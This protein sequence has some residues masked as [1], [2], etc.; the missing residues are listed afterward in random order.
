LV[1]ACNTDQPII[2]NLTLMPESWLCPVARVTSSLVT[3]CNTHQPII[4]K[5]SAS[6]DTL[7]KLTITGLT[8]VHS[9]LLMLSGDWCNISMRLVPNSQS[10]ITDV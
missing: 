6:S 2:I 10:R 1:T 4:V 9:V 8:I 5:Q 3:A 7:T